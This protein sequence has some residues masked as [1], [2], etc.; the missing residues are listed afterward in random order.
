MLDSITRYVDAP[1]RA[2]MS[3]I[4]ILS[5]LGK[6]SAFAATQAYMEAFGLPGALLAPTIAFEV[7]AGLLLFI[8]LG[9]RYAALLMAGFSLVTALVFHRDFADQIQMI[10][11]L[12]NLA[13]TG[14]FLMIAKSG[15]PGLSVDA[16]L[17][18]RKSKVGAA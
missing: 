14:G 6:I 8:G 1:A 7:G 11:F 9:A 13:M 2:L 15:A 4:F 17:A 5:G 12:K 16:L 18:S 10:M 3:I